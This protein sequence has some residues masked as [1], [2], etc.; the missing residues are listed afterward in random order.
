MRI[1]FQSWWCKTSTLKRG[2]VEEWLCSNSEK[3]IC[4]CRASLQNTD[5]IKIFTVGRVVYLGRFTEHCS[6][7]WRLTVTHSTELWALIFLPRYCRLVGL[8]PRMKE[9]AFILAEFFLSGFKFSVQI[10]C[11]LVHTSFQTA[12]HLKRETKSIPIFAPPKIKPWWQFYLKLEM[13]TENE[14]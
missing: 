7:V 1:H 5:I 12:D 9:E 3:R 6:T 11:F 10:S 14:A 13:A 2:G 8:F 4:N